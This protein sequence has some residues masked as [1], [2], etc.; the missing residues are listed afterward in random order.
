MFAS[1]LQVFHIDQPTYQDFTLVQHGVNFGIPS[2]SNSKISK[3]FPYWNVAYLPT[4][5]SK[6]KPWSFSGGFAIGVPRNK[7]RSSA[8]TAAA[9]EFTK[10]MSLVGQ[11]TFER[12]AGNI[13]C[14]LSQT[15]DSTLRSKAHWS[16]FIAALKY[17][18]KLTEDPYDPGYPDDVI[19]TGA[20]FA[21]NKIL[22]G[23]M[24]PKQA[25]DAAQAQALSN[26]K[27]NGGP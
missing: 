13:P 6:I 23:S 26:M 3:I 14:V 10:F 4:A 5:S 27:R 22:D 11:L 25:L 20:P 7:H 17:A 9:W 2:N 15:R 1:G 24:T 18:H 21:Q 8:D 16:T 12:F 19:I